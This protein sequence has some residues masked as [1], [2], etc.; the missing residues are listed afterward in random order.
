MVLKDADCPLHRESTLARS[1]SLRIWLQKINTLIAGEN[2][3]RKLPRLSLEIL[4]VRDSGW[5]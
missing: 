3:L 4:E 1:E 5:S 2:P